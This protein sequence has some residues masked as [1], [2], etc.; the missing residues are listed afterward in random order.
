M[1]GGCKTGSKETNYEAM[2][3]IL[4]N[5]CIYLSPKFFRM[6]E[7]ERQPILLVPILTLLICTMYLVAGVWGGSH[8]INMM[9][10]S[11]SIGCWVEPEH[12]S[13]PSGRRQGI[14]FPTVRGCWNV[15][16]AY[17]DTDC[18]ILGSISHTLQVAAFLSKNSHLSIGDNLGKAVPLYSDTQS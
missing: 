18:R 13:F 1:I 6:W 10:D 2:A 16:F 15:A 14:L 5:V 3:V 9:L 12:P 11:V 8:V 7:K 17:C 4:T